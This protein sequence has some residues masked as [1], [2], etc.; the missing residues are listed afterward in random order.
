MGAVRDQ[1]RPAQRQEIAL[2]DIHE[3]SWL[4]A[5]GLQLNRVEYDRVRCRFIFDDDGRA[6]ALRREFVFDHFT[7]LLLSK[8]R[9]LHH[10]RRLAEASPSRVCSAT[11]LMESAGAAI[12][13]RDSAPPGVA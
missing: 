2:T 11:A 8:K 1:R 7:R 3:S 6:T 5:A 10:A 13:Q 12:A 9:L 4:L